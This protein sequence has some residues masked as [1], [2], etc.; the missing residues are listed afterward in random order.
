M[1]TIYLAI[2]F[3][4]IFYLKQNKIES[5]V[6]YTKN[7]KYI[8]TKHKNRQFV[9]PEYLIDPYIRHSHIARPDNNM[10]LKEW[11]YMNQHE[12][13]EIKDVYNKFYS[14]KFDLS[15]DTILLMYLKDNKV[16][17]F[18]GLL[19]TRQLEKYLSGKKISRNNAFTIID[20][21]GLYMHNLCGTDLIKQRLLVGVINFANETRK[22]YIGLLVYNDNKLKNLL[23]K[24]KFTEFYESD[25]AMVKFNR[26]FKK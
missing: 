18:V 9:H 8:T 3:L 19:T 11:R 12:K 2:V 20:Q 21:H 4:I 1:N 22:T 25:K 26:L 14:N 15:L 10:I 23:R 5:F 16:I 7:N 6:E 17:G 24:Y 13:K